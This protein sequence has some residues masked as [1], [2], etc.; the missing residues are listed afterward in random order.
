MKEKEKFFTTYKEAVHWL[1]NN[2]VLCNN[3]PGVDESVWDNARFPLYDDESE[4]ETDIFQW[5]ITDASESDV[6][7]LEKNFGLLFTYSN[8]LGCF[9]LCV[10]H[11]G[12]SWDYVPCEV[13]TFGDEYCPCVESYEKLTGQKA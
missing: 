10:D 8:K 12:T 3:I 11:W 2:F 9:V 5:F 13:L 1:H 7:Y 4:T 6:E